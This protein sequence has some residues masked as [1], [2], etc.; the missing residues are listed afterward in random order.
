M[1]YG[2]LKKVA[3]TARF[4][5]AQFSAEYLSNMPRKTTLYRYL[6]HRVTGTNVQSLISWRPRVKF[7]K[8]C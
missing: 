3:D 7:P 5:L 4:P 1:V 6:R 2:Y 8:A